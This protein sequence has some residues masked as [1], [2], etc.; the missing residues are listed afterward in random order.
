MLVIMLCACSFISYSQRTIKGTITDE[1]GKVI[2]AAGIYFPSLLSGTETDTSGNFQITIPGQQ[3][4]TMQVSHVGYKTIL[5]PVAGEEV[6]NVKL[7]VSMMEVQE[8]VITAPEAKLTEN[9]PYSIQVYSRE[10]LQNTGGLTLMSQLAYQP[11]VDRISTGIGIGKPVIRGNSFNRIVLQAM[12]TRIEN[13]QWDDRHDL[14]ISEA[15]IDRVE[16]VQGAAALMYGADALG[17]AL[18]FVDE[19]PAMQGK[20]E[21]DVSLGYNL[22]NRG[23]K[24]EFGYKHTYTNGLFYIARVA[25]NLDASYQQ[26]GDAPEGSQIGKYAANSKFI[27][28]TGKATL[29][30][31][32]S[33]GTSRINYSYY[34][35][36][37]GIVELEPDSIV[38][39]EH[40]QQVWEVEAPY[41]DVTTHILS[42][43]NSL[44]V[45]KGKI[46]LD[47]AY[48]LNDRLEYEP[49]N[50]GI[51]KA[52]YESIGLKLNVFTYDIKWISNPSKKAGLIVGS[53]GMT[54]QNRNHGKISLVPDADVSNF[55]AYITGRYDLEKWNFLVGV[56][57]DLRE[58][59]IQKRIPE[60]QAFYF[61]SSDA[62][63]TYSPVTGSAGLAWH[64][65]K[66]I[67]VKL[68]V[69]SGFSAPNYAELGTYGRHEG[70]YRFEIGN[71][72]LDMEQNV[73]ADAGISYDQPGF[74]LHAEGYYN[75]ISNY[76]YLQNSGTFMDSLPVYN[77]LQDD[78]V[79]SGGA[80]GFI[81]HPVKMPFIELSS[82]FSYTRGAREDFD[83]PYI[84][85]PKI[86]TTLSFKSNKKILLRQPF[87]S[88]TMSNYLEQTHVAPY[89]LATDDYMLLD[90]ML[91][92]NFNIGNKVCSL[93]L[94]ATNILDEG[95]YSHLS[96]VKNIEVKD[97]G[98]NIGFHL[99]M[100]F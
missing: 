68:N 34:K 43:Q 66:T 21:G 90:L 27:D 52:K 36:L 85:A 44:N 1:S 5:V 55:A 35:Q 50:N 59:T 20:S 16:V 54:Q 62:N 86:V 69:A 41:Q 53:Q 6:I 23:I 89:E 79:L 57:S 13:Q 24:F 82:D 47:I 76:I 22:N 95:Y 91:G 92:G 97:M 99:S 31:S 39:S 29:G 38:E 73:E 51:K 94:F 64:P 28:G 72:D 7:E 2:T 40:E 71:P 93:R 33:W 83:L 17:G 32:K 45:K 74:S 3:Q 26:G 61:P 11:G 75:A 15:G 67:T 56:R 4:V 70:A 14:G 80:A 78:A 65:V 25:T 81:I 100:P 58:I 49:L 18:I 60:G 19:K 37:I 10:M 63:M 12:G 84:P 48:Q 8:I 9:H 46:N 87:V 77:Y 88:L 96:L 30:I 98:R 42:W